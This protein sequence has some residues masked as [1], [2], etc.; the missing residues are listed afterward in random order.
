MTRKVGREAARSQSLDVQEFTVDINGWEAKWYISR[1]VLYS[2]P[3][4]TR[5]RKT[6]GRKIY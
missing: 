4:E 3:T 6:I 1:T 5:G 2:E